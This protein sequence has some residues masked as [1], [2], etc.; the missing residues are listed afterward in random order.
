MHLI[1]D[2]EHLLYQPMGG[3]FTS[4]GADYQL[5]QEIVAPNSYQQENT[6]SHS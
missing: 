6:I 4:P 2:R 3:S 1:Q 5:K